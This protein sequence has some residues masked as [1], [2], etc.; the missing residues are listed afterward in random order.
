MLSVRTLIARFRYQRALYNCALSYQALSIGAPIKVHLYNSNVLISRARARA[1]ARELFI[2]GCALRPRVR[3][4][5]ARGAHPVAFR[6]FAL[7]I[8]GVP[9]SWPIE[10]VISTRSLAHGATN[11]SSW[12]AVTQAPPYIDSACDPSLAAFPLFTYSLSGSPRFAS[13]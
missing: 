2:T 13:S 5:L 10:R 3:R 11:Y 7:A 4:T 8:R 6:V 9:A 12:L 1:V